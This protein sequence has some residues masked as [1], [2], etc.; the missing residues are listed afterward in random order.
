MFKS[1]KPI[2]LSAILILL[3]IFEVAG[4]ICTP[5]RAQD[6]RPPEMVEI[7]KEYWDAVEDARK[8]T[9]EKIFRN[10]TAITPSN[11]N[12]IWD[13]DG[14]VLVVTWTTWDRYTEK[15]EKQFIPDK[16]VWVTAAPDLKNFCQNYTSTTNTSPEKLALRLNQLLGLPPDAPNKKRQVVEIWVDPHFLFRPSPDPEINDHEAQLDFRSLNQFI[17]VSPNYQEWF[18]KQYA[19]R[20]QDKSGPTH[21]I[22]SDISTVPYPWTQLGYTYDW[23]EQSSNEKNQHQPT[24]VGLSE[25]VISKDSPIFIKS[26]QDAKDYCS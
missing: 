12:L 2:H 14:R 10:L 24:H 25:F 16:D 8:P 5:V 17:S 19:Q 18:Y 3:G 23:V 1:K 22:K 20:Y 13:K 4:A 15:K 9:P 6:S 21:G 7:P 26:V 11:K